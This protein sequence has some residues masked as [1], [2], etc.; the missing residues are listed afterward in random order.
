MINKILTIS[1]LKGIGIVFI[2]S[3]EKEEINNLKDEQDYLDLICSKDYKKG[4]KLDLDDIKRA[5]EESNKLMKQSDVSSIKAITK[6]DN[7]YP[8]KLQRLKKYAPPIL[9]YKGNLS[10]LN[11][12]SIA[13]IGTRKISETGIRWGKR[14]SE[15]ITQKGFIVISGLAK[16]SDTIAHI[17]CIKSG[18]VTVAV[19]PTPLD[20]IQP[21]SNRELAEEILEKNGCLVSE[22]PIGA[23]IIKSNFTERDRIQAG[24][25]SGICVIETGLNGGSHYAINTALSLDIPVSCLD[26]DNDHY[27]QCENAQGNKK[28]IED[29]KSYPINSSE[30]IDFFL[31]KCLDQPNIINKTKNIIQQSLF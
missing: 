25:A 7:Q 10:C 31:K 11:N 21:V 8:V 5:I 23:K 9:F 3:L 4:I 19:L 30:S 12:K 13:I 29:G 22:Y 1:K 26:F 17:G 27:R 20:A 2:N 16:G 28:L 24:L 18:G 6:Y 14:L 15:V